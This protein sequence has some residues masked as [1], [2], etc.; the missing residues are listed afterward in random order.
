MPTTPA[1]MP[2]F[3]VRLTAVLHGIV[4]LVLGGCLACGPGADS[5]RGDTSVRVAESGSAAGEGL[6]VDAASASGLDFW[7]FNGM[8]GELYDAEVFPPG[9]RNPDRH[10]NQVRPFRLRTTCVGRD[11]DHDWKAMHDQVNGGAMDGFLAGEND[12]FAIGYY[13]EEDVPFLPS[14]AQAFTTCDRYFCSLLG[15]TIPNRLYQWAATA[16]GFKENTPVIQGAAETAGFQ[17]PNIFDRVR[18]CP[19]RI[20]ALAKA[21]LTLEH[22]PNQ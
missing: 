22:G 11:P 16:K 21:V 7:H 14:V 8:S 15:P 19:Y 5:P 10:G 20:T 2:P 9:Y 4:P 1:A 3:T 18:A 13:A 6:F 12:E 17:W